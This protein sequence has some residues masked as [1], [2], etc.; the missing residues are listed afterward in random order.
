[1]IRFASVP[2]SSSGIL[3]FV[4]KVLSPADFHAHFLCEESE[5]SWIGMGWITVV[6]SRAGSGPADDAT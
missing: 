3:V 2:D 5:V 4:A 1:M 6:I